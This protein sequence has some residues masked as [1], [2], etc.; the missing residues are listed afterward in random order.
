MATLAQLLEGAATHLQAQMSDTS[1]GAVPPAH[2]CQK[3]AGIM[4]VLTRAKAE[5]PANHFILGALS[6]MELLMQSPANVVRNA[7]QAGHGAAVGHASQYVAALQ[8]VL[9]LVKQAQSLGSGGAGAGASMAS[10]ERASWNI[11]QWMENAPEDLK[12]MAEKEPD[13]YR[14]LVSNGYPTVGKQ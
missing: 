8:V 1:S 10:G 6:R 13:K 4:E 11:Q 12:A 14:A 3:E 2:L 5:A 9:N 7:A